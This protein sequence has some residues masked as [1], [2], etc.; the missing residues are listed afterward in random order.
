MGALNLGTE[1]KNFLYYCEFA[2]GKSLNTIKSLRIDLVK[3]NDY[4]LKSLPKESADEDSGLTDV[5]ES[6]NFK[7]K[8]NE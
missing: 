8:V 5:R 7:F 2:E 3:F 4:I 1:I 6:I